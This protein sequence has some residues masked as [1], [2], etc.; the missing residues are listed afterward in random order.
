LS[1]L[2][3]LSGPYSVSYYIQMLGVPYQKEPAV[4][5][6][7]DSHIPLSIKY[8]KIEYSLSQSCT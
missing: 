8:E 3:S 4:A 5:A 2:P 7:I 1:S 6:S